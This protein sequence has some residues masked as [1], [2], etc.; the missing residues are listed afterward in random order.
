MCTPK[1]LELG[2]VNLEMLYLGLITGCMMAY[3][4]PQKRKKEVIC[5]EVDVM[6]SSSFSILS[7][8]ELK[9]SLE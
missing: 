5:F 3:I 4:L 8:G 2:Q 9:V 1:G 6:S 7:E